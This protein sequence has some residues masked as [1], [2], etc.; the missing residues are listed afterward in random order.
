MEISQL[1]WDNRAFNYDNMVSIKLDDNNEFYYS[2]LGSFFKPF[3]DETEKRYLYRSEFFDGVISYIQKHKDRYP[4][5][6][7]YIN[8]FDCNEK[9]LSILS[10]IINKDIYILD[11]LNW[12][13]WL[14]N[15]S[16]IDDLY[17]DRES[18]VLLKK[19]NTYE[20]VGLNINNDIY[21]LFRTN[22]PFINKIKQSLFYKYK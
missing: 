12:N 3:I 1:S 22:H 11:G 5:L 8:D 17:H 7:I 10:I 15:G 4:G 21:T 16:D 13:V 20:I 2:L 6:T 14:P 19:V 18:I 9:I